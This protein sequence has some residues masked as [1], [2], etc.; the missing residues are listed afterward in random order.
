MQLCSEATLGNYI[1]NK[2]ELSRVETNPT[3]HCVHNRNSKQLFGTARL[4]NGYTRMTRGLNAFTV[5]KILS[6]RDII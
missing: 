5:R 6:R 2:R 3:D 4:N 1:V